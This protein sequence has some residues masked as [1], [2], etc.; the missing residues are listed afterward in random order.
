M[1]L[2]NSYST[3]LLTFK[4]QK[5]QFLGFMEAAYIFGNVLGLFLGTIVF[6]IGGFCFTFYFFGCTALAAFFGMYYFIP[7]SL[8]RDE[9]TEED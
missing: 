4:E 7:N 9:I 1:I 5:D 2:C 3:V 6:G 8:N